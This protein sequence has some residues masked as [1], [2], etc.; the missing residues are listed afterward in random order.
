MV[1]NGNSFMVSK[2]KVESKISDKSL[3]LI[4]SFKTVIALSI[5]SVIFSKEIFVFW[6]NCVAKWF[7]ASDKKVNSFNI[8]VKFLEGSLLVDI[9]CGSL[10]SKINLVLASIKSELIP[11]LLKRFKSTFIPISGE[12]KLNKTFSCFIIFAFEASFLFWLLFKAFIPYLL[13][14]YTSLKS[15]FEKRISVFKYGFNLFKILFKFLLYVSTFKFSAF[16]VIST[17]FVFFV[18]I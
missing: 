6:Y 3:Y 2:D 10:S 17:N 18:F 1:I 15:S 5:S 8:S 9:Y 4:R 12:K 16:F 7:P 11:I 14:I 13:T